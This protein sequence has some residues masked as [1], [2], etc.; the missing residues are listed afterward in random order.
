MRVKFYWA[1]SFLPSFF[2]FP[3]G[4]LGRKIFRAGRRKVRVIKE[5][6]KGRGRVSRALTNKA[7]REN[8][9]F[10]KKC[11]NAAKFKNLFFCKKVLIKSFSCV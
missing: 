6:E 5:R 10:K 8:T 1:P 4:L 3:E 9:F 2:P 7:L 11:K